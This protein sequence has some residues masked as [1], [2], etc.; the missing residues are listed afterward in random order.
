MNI[1]FDLD[2]TL[3]PSG[4]EFQTEKRNGIAKLF[5]IEEIRKGTRKLISELQNEGNKIHIYTT[6]YRTKRKIRF[7]LWY[8]GIKVNRIVT[9]E[10]N[11]RILK[12]R[13]IHSSKY[14]TAF[15]FE[16]HIDDS[17]GVGIEAE[18]YNFKAII[19]DPAE[20]NWAEKI[21]SEIKNVG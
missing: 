18:K 6:S 12:S 2:S 14:P 9:Q 8:Y 10:E 4:K 13:N 11:L 5:G 17:R 1:S 7:T 16:I 21:K 15:E 20:I 19:I 3:I